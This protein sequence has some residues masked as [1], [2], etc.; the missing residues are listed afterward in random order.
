[1]K[2]VII[3][4]MAIA[5][6]CLCGCKNTQSKGSDEQQKADSLAEVERASFRSS[7]L[8]CY[9]LKGHVKECVMKA[10]DKEGKENGDFRNL[11]FTKEGL[12]EKDETPYRGKL[13]FEY[14]K[15]GEFLAGKDLSSTDMKVTLK[16]D[17]NGRIQSVRRQAADGG[18]SDAQYELKY[19]YDKENRLKG[20]ECS[21]WEASENITFSYASK[22]DFFVATEKINTGDYEVEIVTTKSY[23]Y[24]KLDSY[25]NWVMREVTATEDKSITE[26]GEEASTTTREKL[27]VVIEKREIVYW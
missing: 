12:I 16:R 23:N 13:S 22:E 8:D 7:D 3:G 9:N 17:K 2:K 19:S 25:G 5:I 11:S 1:M 15:S 4:F 26:M 14:G 27:P 21:Y 10:Y 20:I 18:D 6:V 24:V